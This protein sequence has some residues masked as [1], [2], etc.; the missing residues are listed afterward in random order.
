MKEHK[1]ILMQE[2]ID[3]LLNLNE[4]AI[5]ENDDTD[6]KI[7]IRL[8]DSAENI[9]RRDILE[10]YDNAEYW[11]KDYRLGIENTEEQNDKT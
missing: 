4:V 1:I 7:I 6:E 8:E 2:E 10:R 3:S 11:E 9:R 5:F